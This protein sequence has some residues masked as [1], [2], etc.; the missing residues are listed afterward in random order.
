MIADVANHREAYACPRH[1]W[2]YVRR[3]GYVHREIP[4]NGEN[5][6]N[7]LILPIVGLTTEIRIGTCGYRPES[8]HG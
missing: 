8:D 1:G 2:G 7:L 5:V 3:V 6:G 4:L